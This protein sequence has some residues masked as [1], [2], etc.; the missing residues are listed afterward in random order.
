M[1]GIRGAGSVLLGLSQLVARSILLLLWADNWL[2][3]LD[4]LGFWAGGSIIGRSTW[5]IMA[6]S[7][8]AM[9]GAV[10]LLAVVMLQLLS[11][12]KLL[13]TTLGPLGWWR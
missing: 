7:L 13:L 1:W 3:W 9:A 8:R 4:Q 6:A 11:A 10:L 2:L 12:S 5:D